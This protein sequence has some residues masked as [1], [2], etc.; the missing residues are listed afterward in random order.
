MEEVK[1]QVIDTVIE[2]E[3][4]DPESTPVDEDNKNSYG[5]LILKDG[6]AKKAKKATNEEKVAKKGKKT[7]TIVDESNVDSV[8]KTKKTTFG[9]PKEKEEVKITFDPAFSENSIII[10]PASNARFNENLVMAFLD[11]VIAEK[12]EMRGSFALVKLSS[13]EACKSI[14]AFNRKD[15]EKGAYLVDIYNEKIEKGKDKMMRSTSFD[16][17]RGFSR[18]SSREFQRDSSREFQRDSFEFGRRAPRDP[19][20]NKFY[21]YDNQRSDSRFQRS[22][23]NPHTEYRQPAPTFVFGAKKQDPV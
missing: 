14:L 2:S 17:G 13:D 22:V 21:E 16:S 20:N 6:S 15:Y 19:P 3:Q 5:G 9:T 4:T 8:I 23:S 18:D 11:G 1:D 7:I 10:A 12:V